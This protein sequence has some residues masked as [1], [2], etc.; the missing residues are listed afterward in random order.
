MEKAAANSE[1]ADRETEARIATNPYN[2]TKPSIDLE[3]K[4]ER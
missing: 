1:Q 4:E 3:H 2:A